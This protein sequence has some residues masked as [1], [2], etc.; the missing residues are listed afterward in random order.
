MGAEAGRCGV[1]DGETGEGWS[2]STRHFESSFAWVESHPRNHIRDRTNAGLA[3]ARARRRTEGRPEK[4]DEQ[5]RQLGTR[6]YKEETP[7]PE[8]LKIVK[9]SKS[10]FDSYVEKETR[11]KS[12]WQ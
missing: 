12:T 2:T 1:V 9:I 4:L 7:I 3:A 8:I 11:R 5:Q 6:L 10:T